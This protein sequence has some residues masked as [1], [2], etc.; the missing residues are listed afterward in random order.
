MSGD[1]RRILTVLGAL[2][3]AAAVVFAGWIL[4][5]A[6]TAGDERFALPLPWW[7]IAVVAVVNLVLGLGVLRGSR[8]ARPLAIGVHGLAFAVASTLLVSRILGDEPLTGTET[9]ELIVKSAI[10]GALALFW[11]RS[12]AARASFAA[13]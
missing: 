6:A 9:R 10:H 8:F 7:A 1:R 3:L 13:R 2:Y 5:A 4:I 11:I 12:P